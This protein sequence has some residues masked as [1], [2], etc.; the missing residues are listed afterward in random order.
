MSSLMNINLSQSH[1]SM[2]FIN[3][4][5]L[6]VYFYLEVNRFSSPPLYFCLWPCISG[7]HMDMGPLGRRLHVHLVGG[8][9]CHYCSNYHIRQKTGVD[10]YSHRYMLHIMNNV[11]QCEK[12]ILIYKVRIGYVEIF[13]FSVGVWWILRFWYKIKK[14]KWT[15][16]IVY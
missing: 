13:L 1:I 7:V 12:T 5:N 15:D 14:G 9:R 2:N 4:K 16:N 11:F 10:L 8:A 3:I 6:V